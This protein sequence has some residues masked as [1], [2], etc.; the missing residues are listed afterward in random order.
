MA[1]QARGETSVTVKGVGTI[2]LCLTMAGMAAL[3]DAFEVDNIQEAV[4]KVGDNPSSRNM[5]TVLH[6]LMMGSDHSHY[7]VEEIRHWP[8]TP[9]AITE[10]MSAMNASNNGDGEAGNVPANRKAR[11]AAKPSK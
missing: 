11:R 3:E 7:I 10:A 6:A 5:A 2:T 8:I 9:S 4:A 1:N